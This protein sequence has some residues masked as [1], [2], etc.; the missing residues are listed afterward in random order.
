V[1]KWG[2]PE[3]GRRATVAQAS[4]DKTTRGAASSVGEDKW[5]QRWDNK[6]SDKPSGGGTRRARRAAWSY[7]GAGIGRHDETPGVF[8][9]C[10]WCQTS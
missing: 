4:K 2:E 1:A 9:L 3:G 5:W 8:E 10:L 6:G 7:R